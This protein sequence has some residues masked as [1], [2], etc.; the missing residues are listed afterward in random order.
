MS[1]PDQIEKDLREYLEKE[2]NLSRGDR[3]T[4]LK[5]IFHKHLEINKLEHLIT[6]QDVFLILG[7]ARQQFIRLKTPVNITRKILDSHEAVHIAL[8]EAFI[9]HLNSKKLLRK[10]IKFDFRD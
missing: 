10:L 9:L 1:D 3:L 2:P 6:Y 7:E 5:T 4:Y 8:M